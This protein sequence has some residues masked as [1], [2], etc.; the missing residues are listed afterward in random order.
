MLY[1]HPWVILRLRHLEYLECRTWLYSLRSE[2]DFERRFY[3]ARIWC[4]NLLI[5]WAWRFFQLPLLSRRL[6]WMIGVLFH[7]KGAAEDIPQCLMHSAREACF[8]PT[9]A[10]RSAESFIGFVIPDCFFGVASLT[11]LSSFA[12]FLASL[13]TLVRVGFFR[14]W[15]DLLKSNDD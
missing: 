9:T 8:C 5:L 12:A 13:V 1:R 15:I 11:E 7:G 14:S 4:T 3:T 6:R 2:W 10:A